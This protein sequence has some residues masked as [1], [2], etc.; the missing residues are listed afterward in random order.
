VY[1][2]K[3]GLHFESVAWKPMRR[4]TYRQAECIQVT[5]SPACK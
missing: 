4:W 3:L 5:L 2:N 1:E